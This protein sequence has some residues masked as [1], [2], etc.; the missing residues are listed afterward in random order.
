[1]AAGTAISGASERICE[2]FLVS[3]VPSI[4][5]EKFYHSSMT[6]LRVISAVRSSS[7]QAE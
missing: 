1:M 4:N 3:G 7:V 2:V 5:P 6:T